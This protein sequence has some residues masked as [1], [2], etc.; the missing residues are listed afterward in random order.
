VSIVANRRVFLETAQALA[1]ASQPTE[2][3]VADHMQA[4]A[5]LLSDMVGVPMVVLPFP[6]KE[7][8]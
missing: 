3:L 6:T 5:A 2:Q 7:P 8:S 4:L 1:K